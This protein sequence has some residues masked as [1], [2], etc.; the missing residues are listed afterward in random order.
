MK[1]SKFVEH[2][3]FKL[4]KS[5]HTLPP[6]IVPYCFFFRKYFIAH[7]AGNLGW[8]DLEC[9]LNL[10]HKT[11]IR[12]DGYIVRICFSFTS[13][14]GISEIVG[15]TGSNPMWCT[16]FCITTDAGYHQTYF[17]S[18]FK[19][20]DFLTWIAINPDALDQLR[21]HEVNLRIIRSYEVIHVELKQTVDD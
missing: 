19:K 7:Q 13:L 4:H 18:S 10:K 6:T 17:K 2:T 3:N 16:R 14:I 12:I 5:F 11:S 1:F 21:P 20:S 15:S 9:S 8:W